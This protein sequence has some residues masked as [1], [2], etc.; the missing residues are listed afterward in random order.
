MTDA[1]KRSGC[2]AKS[3][4]SSSSLEKS[5]SAFG[6]SASSTWTNS[7]EC[8]GP[9]RGEE[10]PVVELMDDCLLDDMENDDGMEHLKSQSRS[11]REKRI[12][13]ITNQIFSPLL[14]ACKIHE[15]LYPSEYSSVIFRS[16]KVKKFRS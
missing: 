1:L 12:H 13:M 15:I 14:T 7:G 6:K 3:S 4:G 2:A 9:R 8:W 16:N 5:S 10:G 11:I